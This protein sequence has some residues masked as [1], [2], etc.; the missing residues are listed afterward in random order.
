MT[1][2][3]DSSPHR[4]LTFRK[5]RLWSKYNLLR[6]QRQHHRSIARMHM[7]L[8]SPPLICSS[9]GQLGAYL[10]LLW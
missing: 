10:V 6:E 4:I 8:G 7:P 3:G 9:A 1:A 5:Q 2:T